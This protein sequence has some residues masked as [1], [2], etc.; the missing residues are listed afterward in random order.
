MLS[1]RRYLEEIKISLEYHDTLNSKLWDGDKL[2]PEVRTALLK[3]ADA[4][5][6]FANIKPSLIQDIVMTGGN[7][8]YNYTS[9][10][11]IDVHVIVDRNKLGNDRAMVDDYL[12]SKKVLWTLTHDI[13]VYGYPLEPYAQ[14][15]GETFPSEQG[16]YSLK[17]N[18]WLQQPKH[19]D[20][21]F[22]N[23][24]NLKKKVQYYKH[25]ID[26]M[27][28][29]KMSTDEFDDLSKKLRTMRGASI[30]KGG[31]FS[32]ENLLFKELRNQGYLDKMDQYQ[33]SVRDKDLSLRSE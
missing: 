20:Y 21:D 17:N 28:K 8:N 32:F 11:D 19:G 6:S 15:P 12:Q 10:S 13:K 30:Q 29:S 2:K 23:D 3:F 5:I 4:W 9:K 25:L 26:Y 14:D 24:S 16:S 7:T 27:I 33:K 1:F 22:A 18:Q 31:E